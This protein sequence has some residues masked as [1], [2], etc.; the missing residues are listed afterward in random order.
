[1]TGKEIIEKLT[2]NYSVSDFGYG[3]IDTVALGIGASVEKVH[4]TSTDGEAYVIRFFPEHNV[5][6]KLKA[7]YN[8]Y[9]SC[10]DFED[11]DV[12]D[13]SVVEPYEKT[14]TAYRKVED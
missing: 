14:I 2:E 9:D 1:M 8:S 13:Y 4:Y 10:I 5:Y 11:S 7:Y 6:I 3:D 12:S